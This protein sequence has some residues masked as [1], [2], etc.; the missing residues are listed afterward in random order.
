MVGVLHACLLYTLDHAQLPAAVQ[1][2]SSKTEQ[3]WLKLC[4]FLSHN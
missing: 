1:G 2:N 4:N 3:V